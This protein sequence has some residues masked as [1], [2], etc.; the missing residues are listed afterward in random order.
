MLDLDRAPE[1]SVISGGPDGE[2][3]EGWQ[4]SEELLGLGA[5][6]EGSA[7][8]GGSSWGDGSAGSGQG[9]ELYVKVR[10]LAAWWC[11]DML[12]VHA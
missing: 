6:E 11:C 10:G 8:G 4:Y 9:P 1:G 3:D 7:G 12:A 5:G 2:D